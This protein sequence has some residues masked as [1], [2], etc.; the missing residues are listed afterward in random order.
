[1]P[2]V[3]VKRV[4]FLVMSFPTETIC[5]QK[6]DNTAIT[7]Q[8]GVTAALMNYLLSKHTKNIANVAGVNGD[9]VGIAIKK[10]VSNKQPSLI[11]STR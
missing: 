11:S 9:G 8:S 2:L 3:D 7:I 10:P 6:R 4:P 1:M 5:H